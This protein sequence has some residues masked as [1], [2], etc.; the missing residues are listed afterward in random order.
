MRAIGFAVELDPS[1]GVPFYDQLFREMI[2]E[3]CDA[4]EAHTP[5]YEFA[6]SKHILTLL[7]R[8]AVRSIHASAIVSP[9]K[10]AAQIAHYRTTAQEIDGRLTMHPDTME[11]GWAWL[12]EAFEGV[13]ISME[14]N[15]VTKKS[16]AVP[17]DLLDV[18]EELP[19]AHWT[20][21]TN[22]MYSR[23][24][25]MAIARQFQTHFGH[26]P[27]L[28]HV[29]GFGG[30]DLPH[31]KLHVTKQDS[32]LHAVQPDGLPVIIESYGK[33]DPTNHNIVDFRPELSYVRERIAA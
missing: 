11:G 13:T 21:D 8:F 33:T 22:H 32:I 19:N 30:P 3:G 14:N 31:T 26:M 28:Y 12:A 2:G 24:P 25:S 16:G 6:R 1:R 29:S 7:Q 10:S 18:F 4:I 27:G 23:D 20:R 15:D 5:D 17:H 9:E